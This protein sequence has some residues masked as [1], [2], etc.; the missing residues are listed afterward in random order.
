VELVTSSLQLEEVVEHGR[1]C[2]HDYAWCVQKEICLEELKILHT[3]S[4]YLIPNPECKLDR[5]PFKY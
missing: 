3:S 5:L 2:K 1:I 4:L